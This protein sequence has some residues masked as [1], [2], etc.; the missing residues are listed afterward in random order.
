M[1]GYIAGVLQG[2][3]IAAIMGLSDLQSRLLSQSTGAHPAV[4]DVYAEY[5]GF[6]KVMAQP[7][8]DL[9]RSNSG[10]VDFWSADAIQNRDILGEYHVTG[11]PT[12]IG[13]ACGKVQDTVTGADQD[14]LEALIGKLKT[15][16]C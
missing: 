10:K 8:A 3:G 6:S 16:N 14:A 15:I 11:L 4:L 5:C 2:A 13:F 7:F 1:T 9:A 12:L